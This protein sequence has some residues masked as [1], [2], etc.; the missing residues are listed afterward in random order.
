MLHVFT[1]AAVETAF[2]VYQTWS[3]NGKMTSLIQYSQWRSTP[4]AG[5]KLTHAIMLILWL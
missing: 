3:N 4:E 2:A 1:S 5:I